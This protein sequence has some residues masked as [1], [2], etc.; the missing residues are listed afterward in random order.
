MAYTPPGV[1]RH[2]R[3]VHSGSKQTRER[4]GGG[5]VRVHVLALWGVR[6][7]SIPSLLNNPP[8][9]QVCRAKH[10]NL[11]GVLEA[12]RGPPLVSTPTNGGNRIYVRVVKSAFCQLRAL[13]VEIRSVRWRHTS[14]RLCNSTMLLKHF[15]SAPATERHGGGSIM[16]RG[17]SAIPFM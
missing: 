7:H 6:S 1:K 17:L 10:N 4:G 11:H 15:S 8:H 12:R 13:A 2:Q 14:E 16:L 5:G 9:S 3:T